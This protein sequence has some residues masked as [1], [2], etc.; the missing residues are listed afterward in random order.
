[1]AN[2][3]LRNLKKAKKQLDEASGP[4]G[5]G[6]SV[7]DSGAAKGGGPEANKGFSNGS[8]QGAVSVD[9]HSSAVP[10]KHPREMGVNSAGTPQAYEPSNPEMGGAGKTQ[11]GASVKAVAREA[12][13]K[14]G[15]SE[16]GDGGSKQGS[17][18]A[19]EMAN[20]VGREAGPKAGAAEVGEYHD[21]DAFRAKVRDA[22]GLPLDD[23]KNKGN[24][25]IK[26][27]LPEGDPNKN[28]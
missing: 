3:K 7:G 22:F 8:A 11:L 20:P 4:V 28:A 24:D 12:G 26:D 13:A 21:M 17:N 10:P 16:V 23:K 19:T 2:R 27:D 1:M 25:G 18:D 14:A 15:R 5:S 9:D 6:K